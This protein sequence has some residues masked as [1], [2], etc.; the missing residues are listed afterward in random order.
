MEHDVERRIE[1]RKRC[2]CANRKQRNGYQCGDAAVARVMRMF[3]DRLYCTCCIRTE[4]ALD[5]MEEFSLRGIASKKPADD[6]KHD[7]QRGRE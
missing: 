5:L 3:D 2:G 6:R 1:R 4:N 7:Q